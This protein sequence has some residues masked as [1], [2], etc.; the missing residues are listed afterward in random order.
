MHLYLLLLLAASVS[1]T[2]AQDYA[3]DYIDR[4][5][6][7]EGYQAYLDSISRYLPSSVTKFIAD[8]S[9]TTSSYDGSCLLQDAAAG[10][11]CNNEHRR[12]SALLL[13]LPFVS[14][15]FVFVMF[16]I[17]IIARS[18]VQE[19]VGQGESDK[20]LDRRNSGFALRSFFKRS[21]SSGPAAR[22]NDTE[23]HVVE[24]DELNASPGHLH[25]M[26]GKQQAVLIGRPPSSGSLKRT[27]S[28][29]GT[30]SLSSS[31][32]S[33]NEDILLDK[34][35]FE[36][37]EPPSPEGQKQ[38]VS[39]KK[40]NTVTERMSEETL[41]DCHAFNEVTFK[42]LNRKRD[43]FD[44]RANEMADDHAAL[45]RVVECDG[46]ELDNS[47]DD[48]VG[49]VGEDLDGSATSIEICP[50]RAS[51]ALFDLLHTVSSPEEMK[52]LH[53]SRKG[54]ESSLSQ[55]KSRI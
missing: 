23:V 48:I 10:G 45:E 15:A 32:R 40:L 52:Q 5:V 44:S 41:D 34:I 26:S 14:F 33:I 38:K 27:N 1:T 24:E 18:R 55:L 30:D 50:E 9:P 25:A 3:A 19:K 29:S 4:D 21:S 31:M 46:D 11:E 2:V 6:F 47:N 8:Y 53:D 37:V 13:A 16:R 20:L 51:G 49:N 35:G 28:V 54:I 39:S 12:H 7:F 42:K 36:E 17:L 22:D 43:S